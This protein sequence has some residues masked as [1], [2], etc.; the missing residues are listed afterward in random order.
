[1]AAIYGVC[2]LATVARLAAHGLLDARLVFAALCGMCL[3]HAS[4]RSVAAKRRNRKGLAPGT[5]RPEQ[6]RSV[7]LEPVVGEDWI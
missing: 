7:P 2:G 6:A 4:W 1:M 3:A 5:R